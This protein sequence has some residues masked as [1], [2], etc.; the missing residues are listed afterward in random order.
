M[1]NK[2]LIC[3][4]ILGCVCGALFLVFDR[5][6]EAT[7]IETPLEQIENGTAHIQYASPL[8]DGM[9]PEIIQ[10][11]KHNWSVAEDLLLKNKVINDL[12]E[13]KLVSSGEHGH[14][15]HESNADGGS[16]HF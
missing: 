4:A 3:S 7:H 8:F 12:D 10:K 9:P 16:F 5:S 2:S 13:W 1:K 14:R 11:I 15:D 6:T